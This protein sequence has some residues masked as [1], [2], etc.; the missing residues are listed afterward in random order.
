M[1]P[2]AVHWS[3]ELNMFHINDRVKLLKAFQPGPLDPVVGSSWECAGTVS[4]VHPSEEM[5]YVEWDCGTA[6]HYMRDELVHLAGTD[7]ELSEG[8][9]NVLFKAKERSKT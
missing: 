1:I 5:F 9:P 7:Q 3:M 6:G 4:A 8:D 2:N